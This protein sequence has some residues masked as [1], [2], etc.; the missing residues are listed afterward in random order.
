MSTDL[1]Q[2]VPP[3]ATSR[4]VVIFGAGSIVAD[5]HLPTYRRLGFTV[6]GIYDPDHARAAAL[7]ARFG[8]VALA[9]MGAAMQLGTGAVYDIA[10]PPDAVAG[11]LSALPE[12]AVVLM[13]KPMGSDLA[14]ADG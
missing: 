5:A 6:A 12:G 11:I 8:T 7:A 3:P 14:G 4:P 2:S 10:V 1:R 9:D 13:Q